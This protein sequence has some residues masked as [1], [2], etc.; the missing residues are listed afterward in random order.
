[1]V[2]A[3]ASYHGLARTALTLFNKKRPL[4]EIGC[5]PLPENGA[6]KE[7]ILKNGLSLHKEQQIPITF[8]LDKRHSPN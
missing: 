1:M 2:Y 8:G 7:Q 3:H 5:F 4:A 6:D